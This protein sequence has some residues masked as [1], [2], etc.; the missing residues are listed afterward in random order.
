MTRRTPNTVFST[1]KRFIITLPVLVFFAHGSFAQVP[2][3]TTQQGYGLSIYKVESGLYPFVQAYIRTF[4]QDK[5]PLVNLNELNIGIMVKGRVY[6]V[7]K[8]QFLVQTIRNREEAIRSVLLIDTSAT[9]LGAPFE[10]ALRAAA[11]YIDAKRPQDQVAIIS[12]N[13][14]ASG[15]RLISNYERDRAALG[16]RLAD[17][18]PNGKQTRLYDGI[19]AAMKLSAMAGAGGATTDDAEY[20]ASS[21]I[22]VFSDGKD[23]GS[24]LSRDDLMTR[25][26]QMSI[27]VPVYSLAYTK[28]APT[29]LKNLQAL[30]NNSFGK[31]YHIGETYD[32]MT[33]VVEQIQHILQNDYVVTFRAYLPVDGETHNLKVGIEYPSRSGKMRYQSSSFEAVEPP[34]VNRI[35]QAQKRLDRALVRLPSPNPYLD[36]PFSPKP[37]ITKIGKDGDKTR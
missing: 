8:R 14:D 2:A 7:A 13:D 9:M 37:V 34:P 27:P 33:S 3:T 21:S 10:N 11:T 28:V 16:R 19:A 18:K 35:L 29:Y 23:E 26:S 36:N 1:F 4:D 5:Q 31:Y 30:S 20:I 22:I 17:L 15:Y 32:K 6:D 24:A 25:I 12:L